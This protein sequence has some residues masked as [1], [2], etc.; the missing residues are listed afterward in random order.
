MSYGLYDGDLILYPQVP[1]FNLELM[2]LSTYYKNKREIVS[3][4]QDFKPNMYSHFLVRQ[5]FPTNKIYPAYPNVEYGGRAFDGTKYK[6]L[7]LD[8]EKTRPD[9]TLY[10]R[11]KIPKRDNTSIKTALSTMR[12]A[13]H[14]RLSLDGKTIWSD[15]ERQLRRE[16]NVHGIIFHDYDLGQIEGAYELISENLNDL[17][18]YQ[19]GRRMGMKFPLT[20]NTDDEFVD[21]YTIPT[22]G[23]YFYLKHNGILTTKIIES[24]KPYYNTEK[25]SQVTYN[26]TRNTTYE[27]FITTGIIDMFKNMLDLRRELIVF[28][29]IYDKGFFADSRWVDVM[30]VI[31]RFNYHNLD[32]LGR[33]KLTFLAPIQT[34][35]SYYKSYMSHREK[36]R[37]R[38]LF[39]DEVLNAFQFLREENYDLFKM[40]YEYTGEKYE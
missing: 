13:E 9:I 29:L 32:V 39:K 4:S 14:V 30:E 7:P 5:D 23:N 40:F 8:V 22:I 25:A 19:N 34:L 10:D 36:Y 3:L 2:K 12:R 11:V 21:W 15:W 28:P 37:E 31:K 24:V 27:E 26:P 35:Y 17:I 16:R 33:G 20:T 18:Y 38:V 1:F 6:P